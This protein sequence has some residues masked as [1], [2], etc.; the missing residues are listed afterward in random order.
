MTELSIHERRELARLIDESA[1]RAIVARYA[2]SL[3]WMN[4]QVQETLFW[5]DAR[6]DFG[7]LFRGDRAA[8]MPFVKALEESYTRRM[9]MFGE[10]RIHVDADDAQVEVASSTHV[11]AATAEGRTDSIIYGRYLL[12]LQR[13]KGEW[14]LSALFYMLNH[15]ASASSAESDAGPLNAADN[16]TMTHPMAPRF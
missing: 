2:N 5:E 15:V 1:I 10:P 16:T 11:R 3:D 4:W 7:D 13:R 14:R 12:G 8:F 6:I 9:H